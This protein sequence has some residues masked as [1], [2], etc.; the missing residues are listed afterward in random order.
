M[1]YFQDVDLPTYKNLDNELKDL[2]VKWF[3]HANPLQAA[4]NL[5]KC[6]KR[7]YR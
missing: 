2:N 3:E 6:A 5:F 1:K 7:I 4:Q